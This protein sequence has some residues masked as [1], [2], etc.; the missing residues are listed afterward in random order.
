MTPLKPRKAR[1][2]D[3]SYSGGHAKFWL[4]SVGLAWV[5]GFNALERNKLHE[6]VRGNQTFSWRDGMSSLAA[7]F[8]RLAH[9][10]RFEGD[11]F[12]VSLA[13]GRELP[14]PYAW[15]PRLLEATPQ[16]REDYRLIGNGVGLHLTPSRRR[17][18]RRGPAA[19]NSLTCTDM[20]WTL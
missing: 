18:V 7:E 9:T 2:L 19:G 11:S 1:E 10:V 8:E 5:R 14:V 17:S 20:S 6:I 12:V 16:Q 13:D 15:F 4:S 3:P